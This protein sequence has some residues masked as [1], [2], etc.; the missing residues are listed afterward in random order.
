[1]ERPDGVDDRGCAVLRQLAVV[2]ERHLEAARPEDWEAQD[3]RPH[4]V[5]RGLR[6]FTLPHPLW[7]PGAPP[8]VVE[9]LMLAAHGRS[10]EES[11]F[12]GVTAEVDRVVGWVRER[13]PG[14]RTA[15]GD[16]GTGKSAIVGRVVCLSNPGERTGLL[17]VDG[18]NH[19]RPHHR[20][21][22]KVHSP[23]CGR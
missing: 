16:A 5:C 22:G 23:R 10:I 8:Q 11:W 13:T 17:H 4:Y 12:I 6:W 20:H 15:T 7:E 9:Q 1:M 2:D 18:W 19:A 21:R 14:I 3:Q